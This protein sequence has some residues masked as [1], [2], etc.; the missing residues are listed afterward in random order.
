MHK[1]LQTFVL[2]FLGLFHVSSFGQTGK[3]YSCSY[4]VADS[5]NDTNLTFTLPDNYEFGTLIPA[6]LRVKNDP[7]S[8]VQ[9][10]T[11]VLKD[12]GMN[13]L[14][15]NGRGD[16]IVHVEVTTPGKLN[17]EQ[18]ELLK[19]L[20]KSRGEKGEDVEIHRRSGAHTTGFF[21]RFRDAF[22]R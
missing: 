4:R 22:N 12:L 8:R 7:S 2:L 9:M 16:L 1:I 11:V 17:K 21:G 20:A 6:E 13:K 14:R 19:S 5:G 10:N 15:G 18:E 3:N